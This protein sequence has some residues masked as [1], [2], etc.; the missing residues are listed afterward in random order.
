MFSP[1]I[2]IG[3]F[4]VLIGS[5]ILFDK[6]V[7]LEYFSYRKEWDRDGKPHGFFWVPPEARFAGGWLV[8]FRSSAAQRRKSFTWLFSTPE[9][10]QSNERALR[11]VFWLQILVLS[12]N[13]GLGSAIVAHFFL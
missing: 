6:L 10:M 13:I 5:F 9:W 1:L 11:L 4:P 8:R 7:R 3:L 12:W 2:F